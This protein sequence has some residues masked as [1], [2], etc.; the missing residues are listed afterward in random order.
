MNIVRKGENQLII[1]VIIL[2]GDFQYR[3]VFFFGEIDYLVVEYLK[4]TALMDKG[5]KAFDAAF[6]VQHLFNRLVWIAH[7]LDNDTDACI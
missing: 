2:H 3:I 5:N 1:A 6:I 7:I 4:L